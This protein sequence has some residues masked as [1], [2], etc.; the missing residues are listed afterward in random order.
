MSFLRLLKNLKILYKIK[1]DEWI[2]ESHDTM[3]IEQILYEIPQSNIKRPKIKFHKES[4]QELINSNYSIAR[5]GDGEISIIQGNSIPFQK[6]NLNLA[7]RLQKILISEQKNLKVGINYEYYYTNIYKYTPLAQKFYRFDVPNLR[8]YLS[9]LINW[10]KEYFSAGFTQ[11]YQIYTKYDFE[12]HYNNLRKIW[13]NKN[14]LIVTCKNVF[15][16]IKYNIFDN[17]A[18]ID[19][20]Y[21]PNK[22]AYEKYNE[23]Y[24]KIKKFNKETLIILIAG[25]TAKV[26]ASDLTLDNYRALDL[27]HL[28]KDYDTFRK[29]IP[30][31]KENVY[32]FMLPD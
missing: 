26:L 2:L 31:T 22:H 8:T 4:V 10:D 21:I 1:L 17:A 11:L 27:G 18:N 30:S 24:S 29:K 5:F 25:P 12:E 7:K 16:N 9:N 15:D 20:L 19:Y 28:A 23:I 14:I 32:K 3:L 13:K 6:Y